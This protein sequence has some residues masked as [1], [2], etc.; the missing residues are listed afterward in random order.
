VKN[1]L[2]TQILNNLSGIASD[3]SGSVTVNAG[4]LQIGPDG[5]AAALA[6][7]ATLGESSSVVLT[8]GALNL[9]YTGT[10]TVASLDFGSGS[11][12]DGVYGS[13]DTALI[14]GSGTLT[15]FTPPAVRTWDGSTDTTW[16]APTDSTS[17]TAETY[18]D[19]DF[20][21]FLETGA[22]T[23]TIS[24]A[25]APGSVLVNSTADYTFSGDAISG[26]TGLTKSGTSDLTLSSANTY[27]GVTTINEGVL[28]ISNAASLG[29]TA[30]NTV[31]AAAEA[32]LSVTG[33]ITVAE[34]LDLT[35]TGVGGTGALSSNGN[36]TVSGAIT[37]AGGRIETVDGTGKLILTGGVTGTGAGNILVG[38]I[39][40]DSLID[41]GANGIFLAGSG[42][43][44]AGA[45]FD[46]GNILNL[47]VAGN[48]WS[49]AVLFF[50]ANVKLGVN[51]AI[52]TS[53]TMSFGFSAI[54]FST[55]QLD[56][57]GFDQTLASIE[58]YT[59][60]VNG[61]VN[62]TGTGGTLTVNQATDTEYQGRI[63]GGIALVKSG[64][65]TL[66]LNNLSGIPNS[67][68]G[69]TT[70]AT[71]TLGIAS[72]SYASAITV[73]NLASLELTVG[74]TV[75]SSAALTLDGGSTIKIVGSPSLASYTLI[76]ASAIT[77]TP[78]LDAAIPGYE[79][80]VNGTDLE[81]NELSGTAYDT[82]SALFPSLSDATSTL[83]FDGG[84]LETGLEYVLGGD[85][86]DASDDLSIAPTST[87]TGS[88]L[89]FVYN[90]ADVAEADANTSIIVQYGSDLSGWA[91]AEHG[92][93]GVT[94]SVSDDPVT[95]GIDEVTVT[96]PNTLAV[97]DKLF[98]R[99]QAVV[100][101]P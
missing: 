73:Q 69:A 82:W 21:S 86:T 46:E 63:T 24:G 66:T 72:G 79:L 13:G 88:A 16:T 71:G 4:I 15:V 81:L 29:S 75:T 78:V 94:I 59:L 1:G 35:G 74:S 53:S 26:S 22:G 47:N 18:N 64:A 14:T 48:T 44:F 54:D 12:A 98:A 27:T 87:Y 28:T 93:A 6:P 31:V 37:M 58:T 36:N 50:D 5:A 23:V 11:V 101:I 70:V 17:W 89:V 68:T 51:N 76:S 91:T 3:F 96:L 57:N 2:G 55:V 40:A 77:G 39:Q 56:L 33:G 38:D 99:L 49:N 100:T 8:G 43:N 34:P 80:V 61:D 32:A 9:N 45:G 84:G 92:T 90:R 95:V 10:Q 7:E 19:G 20:V 62:I 25:V 41:V 65:G 97:G 85:P 42:S 67:H 60:D 52:A 30:G 83:D